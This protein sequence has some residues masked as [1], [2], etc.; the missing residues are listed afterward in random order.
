MAALTCTSGRSAGSDGAQADFSNVESCAQKECRRG[1]DEWTDISRLVPFQALMYRLSG[2]GRRTQ[3]AKLFC[4]YKLR[5]ECGRFGGSLLLIG[6]IRMTG[7]KLQS[8]IMLLFKNLP[9]A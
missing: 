4:I 9:I 1:F 6:G 2:S 7:L 3:P 8:S 5:S